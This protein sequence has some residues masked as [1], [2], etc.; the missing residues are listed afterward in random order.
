MLKPRL[1]NYSDWHILQNG[2][3]T[4]AGQETDVAAIRVDRNNKQV[5]FKTFPPF[6][7]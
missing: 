6:V 3:I 2:A 5:V 1:Y 7:D 4:V